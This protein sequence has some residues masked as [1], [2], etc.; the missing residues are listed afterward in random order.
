MI[1]ASLVHA[2]IMCAFVFV[3]VLTGPKRDV[4]AVVKDFADLQFQQEAFKRSSIQ[5]LFLGR[6][7]VRRFFHIAICSESSARSVS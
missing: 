3:V 2:K 6:L 4:V 1:F 5:R 7:I